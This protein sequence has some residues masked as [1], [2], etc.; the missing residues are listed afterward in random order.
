[1]GEGDGREGG[2]VASPLDRLDEGVRDFIKEGIE[3]LYAP[4]EDRRW[5]VLSECARIM[6]G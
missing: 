1:M 5:R 4:V 6:V 2:F 3:N